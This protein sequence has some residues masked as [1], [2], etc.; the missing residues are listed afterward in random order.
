[1]PD[2]L[3]IIATMRAQEPVAWARD[4]AVVWLSQPS[5]SDWAVIHTGLHKRQAN[6]A[7]FPVY[8]RDP[9][10]LD[11]L[12]AEIERLARELDAQRV[13]ARVLCR[14][15]DAATDFAGTVA[16][17]ASWWDDVWS[18]HTAAL[19]SARAAIRAAKEQSN[20]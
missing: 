15:V 9:A 5:R 2:P 12:Q 16:G 3:Q 4:D 17:G 18:E 7:Q 20:G 6:S 13:Y 10:A 8:T 14:A 11:A 19:D 1:M